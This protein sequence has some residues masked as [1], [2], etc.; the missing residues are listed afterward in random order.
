MG[1]SPTPDEGCSFSFALPHKMAQSC[2]LWPRKTAWPWGFLLP[3]S[4]LIRSRRRL[5]PFIASQI[6]I[7]KDDSGLC[8]ASDCFR[9]QI[10][11]APTATPSVAMALD[12]GLTVEQWLT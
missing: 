9:G 1:K 8:A 4:A 11:A 10:D 6:V 5:S 3:C 12:P 7:L 2:C